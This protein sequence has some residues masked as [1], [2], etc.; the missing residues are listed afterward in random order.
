MRGLLN[1]WRHAFGRPAND[2][3]SSGVSWC[4]DQ[5][6]GC[7]SKKVHRLAVTQCFTHSHPLKDWMIYH[8]MDD[9]PIICHLHCM[10]NASDPLSPL[11][12]QSR[13]LC[14]QGALESELWLER[15]F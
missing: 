6:T 14:D 8:S 12:Q 2:A 9:L 15:V 4:G 7:V 11:S 1:R 3:S 10:S 5:E 13:C